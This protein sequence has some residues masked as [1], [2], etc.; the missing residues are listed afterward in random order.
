MG[1]G[2]IVGVHMHE[3]VNGIQSM[4]ILSHDPHAL[5]AAASCSCTNLQSVCKRLEC[6]VTTA[7]TFYD[8]IPQ[9]LALYALLE[10]FLQR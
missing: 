4:N 5:R 2:P 8:L 7:H 3:M 6:S 1:D 9:D 10:A